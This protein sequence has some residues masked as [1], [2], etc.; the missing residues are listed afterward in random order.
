MADRRTLTFST[1]DDVIAD[2]GRLRRGYSKT[3]NWTLPQICFHL[4]YPIDESLRGILS[5]APTSKQQQAQGFL[6]QVNESGWPKQKLD[7]PP[8]MRPPERADESAIEQY[9]AS[10]KKLRDYHQPMVEAF[11]FGPIETDRLRR[12]MLMHAAH[13]LSFLQPLQRRATLRYAT[14]ADAVADVNRLRRGHVQVGNWTLNQICWH[15]VKATE[16]SMRP[17]PFPPMTPEQLAARP[18]LEMVLST[19]ALP[20]QINAPEQITPPAECTDA[21]MDR[22]AEV[23]EKAR[24][25]PGP[26]APHRIFG[27]LTHDE[28]RRL[29]LVHAAHHL[30]HLVPT[31]EES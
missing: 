7:S 2:I 21:E 5:P 20:G 9:L 29:R 4:A 18:K 1:I 27:E 10:L 19:G 25:F 23:L 26:F 30:S 14:E 13:H 11:L 16:F 3:G 31:Q 17:G 22:L 24:T 28:A 8:P 15:L 6:D 12:F